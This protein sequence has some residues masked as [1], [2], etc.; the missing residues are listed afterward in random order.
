MACSIETLR[1]WSIRAFQHC[2][3]AIIRL[4]VVASREFK[5]VHDVLLLLP[6]IG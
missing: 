3:V 4:T 6:D 1:M 5:Q 2:A